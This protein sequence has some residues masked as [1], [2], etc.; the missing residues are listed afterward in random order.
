MNSLLKINEKY[1]IEVE[2][3]RML[4]L[5]DRK[6]YTLFIKKYM[7]Y[8]AKYTSIIG[9]N[10]K[11]MLELFPKY[12]NREMTNII[13]ISN[14]LILGLGEKEYDLYVKNKTKVFAKKAKENGIKGSK[15]ALEDR[16]QNPEKYKNI[17]SNQLGYWLKQGLSEIE[18]K[19]KLKERQTTFSLD[20]CIERYGEEKGLKVFKK[21]QEKWQNTLKNKPQEEVD[22]MSRKK[23]CLL[24]KTKEEK[25]AYSKM[26]SIR[27]YTKSYREKMRKTMELKN[28]WTPLKYV[29][30]YTIYKNRV[31]S[32]TRKQNLKELENFDKRGTVRAGGHH[33]DHMYSMYQG[34]KNNIPPYILGSIVNLEMVFGTDNISKGAKCS[35]ELNELYFK[36]FKNFR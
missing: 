10:I 14:F 24:G 12:L 23:N 20:K 26:C 1:N 18:A 5:I 2:D 21:R 19:Q 29:K 36:F 11:E 35:I 15:K 32:V 31:W 30:D 16:K 27:N 17:Q 4:Q 22:E 7:D 3:A 33:I 9:Y 34:F 28:K 6:E 13:T 25:E 8:R